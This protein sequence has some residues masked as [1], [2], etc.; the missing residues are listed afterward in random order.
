V[1]GKYEPESETVFNLN[2]VKGYGAY[3]DWLFFRA[4]DRIEAEAQPKAQSGKK[5]RRA[6]STALPRKGVRKQVLQR[7]SEEAPNGHPDRFWDGE[8]WVS[9]N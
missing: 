7:T 4:L 6:P 3:L 5:A 1:Y 2:T 8:S 9:W